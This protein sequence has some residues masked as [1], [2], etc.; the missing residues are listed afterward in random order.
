MTIPFSKVAIYMAGF[1]LRKLDW[2]VLLLCSFWML[3]TSV[4]LADNK[5]ATTSIPIKIIGHVIFVKASVNDRGPF[6]F[7]IDTGATE[8]VITPQSAKRAGITAI[9]TGNKKKGTAK[10]I[11]VGNFMV[12]DLPVIIFDPPQALSL[13]LDKGVDYSGILGYTFLSHFITTINYREL[14]INFLPPQAVASDENTLLPAGIK[15]PLELKERIIFVKGKINDAG[16][17]RFIVDTGSAEV[18]LLPDVAKALKLDIKPMPGY[19]N[20]WFTHLRTLS[21]ENAQASN[22]P[23]VIRP[24]PEDRYTKYAYAGIIGT[25]FLTNFIVSVDYKDAVLILT[26]YNEEERKTDR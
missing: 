13:R 14:T 21:I 7:I 9:G 26:P 22:V 12:R 10:S 6:T 17:Y 18:L 1:W 19:E 15:V 8:T 11:S 23:T 20:V 16:P 2:D 4:L 3:T 25:P 5:Q 24:I